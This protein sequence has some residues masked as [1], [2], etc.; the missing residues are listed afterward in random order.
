MANL[1][2]MFRSITLPTMPEVAHELIRT[3]N[4]EDTPAA[5]VRDAIV[6]DPAL[7]AKL[8]RMA[9]SARFGMPRQIASVDDAIMLAGM[10]QVR[11]LAL[12]SC[13]NDA[14]PMTDG[15]DRRTFWRDSQVCAGYAQWL[16]GGIGSDP[17]KA[18]L[19]G[20][21]M[22]LG[23]IVMGEG[24]PGCLREI[25][26]LP[27]YPGGRWQREASLLGFTEGQVTAE[28]ARRWNFPDEMVRALDTA[29]DPMAAR[30]FSRLGAVLHLAELLA[31]MDLST[32]DKTAQALSELPADV[33]DTL[34]VDRE[35]LHTRL[36]APDSFID[37]TV[38]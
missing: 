7:T 14:F 16:A 27:H 1:N 12:S 15:L 28:L 8:L 25:E 3:L 2:D 29:A 20:F 24:V 10:G 34:K 19:T 11:T 6:R 33:L 9:N 30:P 17:Q 36:P 13:L 26:K 32:P 37:S 22:R 31:E 23:E 18:W 35:W 21:M 4:D 38:H 5:R